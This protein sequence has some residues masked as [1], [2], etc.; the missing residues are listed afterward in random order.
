MQSNGILCQDKEKRTE[1]QDYIHIFISI[2]SLLLF[3]KRSEL[4]GYKLNHLER[5]DTP[6]SQSFLLVLTSL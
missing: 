2:F 6:N 5:A 1:I 4:S 3:F